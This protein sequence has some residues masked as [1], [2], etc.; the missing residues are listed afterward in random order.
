[1]DGRLTPVSLGDKITSASGSIHFIPTFTGSLPTGEGSDES[2]RE[3]FVFQLSANISYL[4]DNAAEVLF[5]GEEKTSNFSISA[6]FRARLYSTE[7]PGRNFNIMFRY[8][9]QEVNGSRVSLG[10]TM[11]PLVSENKPKKT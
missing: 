3:Q 2:E 10:F 1:M 7:N 9:L 11:A 8:N 5:R 6:E 4:S